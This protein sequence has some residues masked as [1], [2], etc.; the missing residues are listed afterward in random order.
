MT[1]WYFTQNLAISRLYDH[2]EVVG[3]STCTGPSCGRASSCFQRVAVTLTS[4]AAP[5]KA[6]TKYHFQGCH[7]IR[8]GFVPALSTCS[9]YEY[10]QS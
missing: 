10:I 9:Q 5:S 3:V 8:P 4:C 7:M 6:E 1:V 2:E